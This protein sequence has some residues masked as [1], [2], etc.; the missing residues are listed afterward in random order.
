M[1][2]YKER[3]CTRSRACG[4]YAHAREAK[5]TVMAVASKTEITVRRKTSPTTH[6]SIPRSDPAI[7]ATHLELCAGQTD[8][9]PR[10]RAKK[11]LEV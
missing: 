8:Q 3:Y 5:P 10:L 6:A 11:A 4:G 9:R 7:P 2:L 1:D